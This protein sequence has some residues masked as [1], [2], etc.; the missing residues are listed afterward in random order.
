MKKIS[1]SIL[2]VLALLACSACNL[3][4]H[5]AQTLPEQPGVSPTLLPILRGTAFPPAAATFTPTMPGSRPATPP[6]AL[7][8]RADSL[9]TT[10]SGTTKTYPKIISWAVFHPACALTGCFARMKNG[11]KIFFG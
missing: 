5:G 11:Q 7:P 8:P 9:P 2:L 1:S 4:Q 6:G 3:P 10:G